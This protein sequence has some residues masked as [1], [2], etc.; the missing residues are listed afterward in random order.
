MPR[1][2][3][4]QTFWVEDAVVDESE[5]EESGGGGRADRAKC[6]ARGNAWTGSLMSRLIWSLRVIR[7]DQ[8]QIRQ[9][10]TDRA[11]TETLS[12]NGYGR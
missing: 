11:K 1:R 6:D 2:S 3:L 5:I 10:L 12:Q 9:G 7:E 8:T 4:I